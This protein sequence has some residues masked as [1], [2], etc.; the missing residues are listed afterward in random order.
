MAGDRP[1][2][3]D[4]AE[5]LRIFIGTED[6]QIVAHRVLEHSIRAHA[7]IPLE[8]TPMLNISLP[9]PTDPANRARVGF[10]FTRFLIPELC[11]YQGRALYIDADMLV[12]GDVAELARLPFDG[13]KILCTYQ[14]E[15][16]ALWAHKTYFRPGRNVAVM[17]LD[18]AQLPW[19][20]DEIV[21]GLDEGRYTY[22]QLIYKLRLVE[23]DAV[24]DTIPPQWN[25][26]ERF[27]PGVTKLLHYTVV[28]TQPWKKHNPL[29]HLWVEAFAEALQAGA[30]PTDEVES[31][32]AAG[33]VRRSLGELLE[34]APDQGSKPSFTAAHRELALAR[35]RIGELEHRL[36]TVLD[37]RS[38]QVGRALT[39]ALRACQGARDR[40]KPSRP[41]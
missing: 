3:D 37:S 30:V 11:G 2:V 1:K 38:W 35:L 26:L 31:A 33:Y 19:K 10:S 40:I 16:P 9:V 23:P 32:I 41:A 25:H 17:L 12:F 20:A 6:S 4:A 14:R 22:E 21:A 18:C 15:L 8:I 27:E 39:G 36:A 34:L 29:G 5:P 24:A 7:T 28:H 13:K